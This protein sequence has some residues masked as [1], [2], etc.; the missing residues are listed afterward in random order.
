MKQSKADGVGTCAPR[1]ALIGNDF[2]VGCGA[3]FLGTAGRGL[4]KAEE[5][6]LGPCWKI[7]IIGGRG[8]N[9]QPLSHSILLMV[10]T[11]EIDSMKEAVE[12]KNDGRKIDEGSGKEGEI[13]CDSVAFILAGP[14]VAEVW[15]KELALLCSDPSI[16]EE[17]HG[18]QNTL[19]H[20][21]NNSLDPNFQVW[22]HAVGEASGVLHSRKEA[23]K[24]K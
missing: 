13:L 10:S 1:G 2:L 24:R 17:A 7:N 6:A 22:L 19:C 4:Q 14:R 9:K 21:C 15:L 23:G 20:I 3:T 18:R 16:V 11:S 8:L 5:G 12:D